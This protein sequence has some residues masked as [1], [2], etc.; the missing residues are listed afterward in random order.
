MTCVRLLLPAP[1]LVV[2]LGC[3]GA[4]QV[5]QIPQYEA[6]LHPLSETKAA[7]TIAV[8]PIKSA[9]RSERYFCADLNEEGILPVN[10]IV[11]NHGKQPVVVKPSDIALYRANEMVDPLP[12]QTVAAVAKRLHGCVL[13]SKTE[14][15]VNRF[16]EGLTFKE[17]VLLPNESHRGIVFFAVPPPKRMMDR[18]FRAVGAY[19]DGDPKIRAG[20]TNLDTG[21]RILFGPFSLAIP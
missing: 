14:E 11:S 5:M 4:F 9:E 18:F 12:V 2:L 1:I 6:D 7:V 20:A 13:R 17:T 19:R 3:A 16:F 21:E 10:V 8:D 15:H